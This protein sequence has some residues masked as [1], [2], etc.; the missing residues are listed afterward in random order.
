MRK[1][2]LTKSNKK[3]GE[4]IQVKFEQENGAR[5]KVLKQRQNSKEKEEFSDES[6]D[7]QRTITGRIGNSKRCCFQAKRSTNL[8]RG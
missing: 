6:I 1:Q 2:F 5:Y 3:G 8:E 7:T 4:K